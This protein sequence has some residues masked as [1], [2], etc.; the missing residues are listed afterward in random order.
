MEFLFLKGVTDA[1]GS[2]AATIPHSLFMAFQGMFAIIT[3][4][5]ITG[6]FVGRVRLK[7]FLAF[8]ILWSVLIYSPVCHWVWGGGFMGQWGLMDFAGGTVVHMTAGF[9]ALAAALVV[10]RSKKE[11]T[12]HNV[13]MIALGTAL[14]WFGWFGFNAGSALTSGES[15]SHAF[16]TT[17]FATASAMVVWALIEMVKKGKTSLSGPC[18]G[19]VVGLIAITPAAGFISTCAAIGLGAVASVVSY[20]VAQ[21]VKG[22]SIED[23]LDVFAC[24]G[25]AGLVGILYTGLFAADKG[26][27]DQFMIQ[28]KGAAI[29]AVYSMVVTF[30]IL[31]VVGAVCGGLRPSDADEA[32]GLDESEHGESA[33]A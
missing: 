13:P 9:S 19:A 17:H 26:G 11:N 24:H 5:L 3:P 31:K 20:T 15:A 2:A 7:P 22:T 6:A 8:L 12:A 27:M 21:L 18:I 14:L 23:T 33:Y 30:I 32:K 16:V 4:A 25:M 29:V 1:P 28:L 10:G